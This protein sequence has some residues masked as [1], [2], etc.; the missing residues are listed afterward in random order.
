[1][2]TGIQIRGAMQKRGL[3]EL[4]KT[5]GAGGLDY[6]LDATRLKMSKL[7][8]NHFGDAYLR[9]IAGD[10]NNNGYVG[11]LERINPALG[12]A[13]VSP[14]VANAFASGATYEIWKFGIKGDEPDR[15]RDRALR[16]KT[17]HWRLK[18]LS[19]LRDVSE[20]STAAYAA[21]A[22]G[23]TNAAG[24]V[25]TLDFPEEYFEKAMRVSNSGG[26]GI[27]ASEAYKVQP[28]Q[29]YRIFGYVS[30]RADTP[31]IRIRNLAGS[32]VALD[33]TATFTL[34][35]W[36]YFEHTFTIPAGC[37]R[38]EV[39]L[40]GAAAT[41]VADWAGIGLL[42]Q[43]ATE[44]VLPSRVRAQRNVGRVF[45]HADQSTFQSADRRGLVEIPC[46]R[47]RA[48]ARVRLRFPH[49]VASAYG[50][51]YEERHFFAALQTD[52]LTALDRTT[53]DAAS[54][55]CPLEYIEAATV[56]ELLESM[57]RDAD[58]EKKYLVA[59]KDLNQIERDMGPEP[60]VPPEPSRGRPSLRRL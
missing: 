37:E 60:M 7:A 23:V 32:D 35:G 41:C 24:A 6:L 1:M 48:A 58:L 18:A 34:M 26:N 30:A 16:G 33:Q 19:V 29:T 44:I 54:T 56:V 20:W 28:Q 10:V 12:Y 27:L 25:Q 59:V 46:W 3:V 47:E 42:P 40:G 39:W 57:P 49:A 55:D 2:P 5:T 13:Y 31:S 36:Q 11:Q 22:G 52:Y 14:P 15:A 17:S 8:A 53:G 9:V 38:I 4:G 21:G 45:L 50:V 43:Q 51:Y